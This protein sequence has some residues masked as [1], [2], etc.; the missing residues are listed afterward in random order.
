MPF[1]PVSISLRGLFFLVFIPVILFGPATSQ[2]DIVASVIGYTFLALFSLIFVV[3]ILG[4]IYVKRNLDLSII[5][6]GG[7]TRLYSGRD[8]VCSRERVPLIIKADGPNLPPF[9]SLTVTISWAHSW[10]EPQRIIFS[11]RL[12]KTILNEAISFP[13]RGVWR[14]ASIS[15]RFE[16]RLGL[17]SFNWS[18]GEAHNLPTLKVYP[19]PSSA[20]QIP[21]MSSHFRSGDTL[22]DIDERAGEFFDLKPY[23]PADGV[24]RILWKIYA[25]SGELISRHPERAMQPEGKTSI[26]VAA[27]RDEDL[28]ASIALAYV[29]MI[30]D[31]GLQLELA[32]RGQQ[33]DPVRSMQEAEDLTLITPGLEQPAPSVLSGIELLQTGSGSSP[34]LIIFISDEDLSSLVGPQSEL[35]ALL[36]NSESAP[37]FVVINSGSAGRNLKANKGVL[38]KLLVTSSPDDFELPSSRTHHTSKTLSTSRFLSQAGCKSIFI[39][40]QDSNQADR[41][42]RQQAR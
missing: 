31:S 26:F 1:L 42:Y 25:R 41:L 27:N 23:H 39:A 10:I 24:N 15:L 21:V 4:G 13:Y 6:P 32:C 20:A 37:F 29:A 17:G 30:L 36:S 2:A 22:P 12:R 34:R 11:G 19:F 33:S 16:D 38:E 18:L 7:Q 14:I 9:F 8:L 3:T 35:Q 5:M 28:V 40:N